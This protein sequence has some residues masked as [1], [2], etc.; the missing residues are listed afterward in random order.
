M[1]Y[2][3]W[4]KINGQWDEGYCLCNYFEKN[5]P[6]GE[7]IYGNIFY[8][9]KRSFLGEALREYKYFNCYK[10]KFIIVKEIIDGIDVWGIRNNID[11]I[12]SVPSNTKRLY[13]P[14]YE[15]VAELG[16]KLLLP[17][18]NDTLVKTTLEETKYKS[19]DEKQRIIKGN[20]ILN[21]KANQKFSAL[22]IDDIFS[23]GITLKEC[24]KVLNQDMN[25]DKLYVLAI[26]K[27]K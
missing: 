2:C 25:L 18:S 21:K 12:I 19:D 23:P 9:R 6:L 8:D 1:G 26:T 11:I 10:N 20:I 4:I 15:I 16:E 22:L 27:T 14:V 3:D 24:A 7:D 13:Q 17:Y 5:I